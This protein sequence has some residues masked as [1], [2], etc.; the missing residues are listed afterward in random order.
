MI[1]LHIGDNAT[2]KIYDAETEQENNTLTK[3]KARIRE[4]KDNQDHPT[5]VLHLTF[6][7]SCG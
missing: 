2:N 3:T 4:K 7:A 6:G 1:D 5:F